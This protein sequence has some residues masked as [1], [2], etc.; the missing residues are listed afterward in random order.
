LKALIFSRHHLL[1][2]SLE[3]KR[4]ET[5]RQKAAKGGNEFAA[6][7]RN[8]AWKIAA[9]CRLMTPAVAAICRIRGLISSRFN[10]HLLAT[11]LFRR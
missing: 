1:T 3:K 4:C 11:T 9:L 5:W 6:I 8:G 10:F 7:C 2:K